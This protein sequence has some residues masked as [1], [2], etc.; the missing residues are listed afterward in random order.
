[1]CQCLHLVFL[2]NSFQNKKGIVFKY[3]GEKLSVDP[4]GIETSIY[5]PDLEHEQCR[6]EQL[7]TLSGK[8]WSL[9]CPK[10]K[11]APL[12]RPH[13]Y[14]WPKF[15]TAARWNRPLLNPTTFESFINAF[16]P[17]NVRGICSGFGDFWT[18]GPRPNRPKP[19]TNTSPFSKNTKQFT[20]KY[21]CLTS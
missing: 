12:L 18:L 2:D 1:M 6:W 19:Q 21:R 13:M 15:V 8:N 5:L 4:C 9:R 3:Y 16:S 20:T 11:Q 14:S 7:N 17:N 10:P